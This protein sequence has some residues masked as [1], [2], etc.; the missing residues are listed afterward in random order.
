MAGQGDVSERDLASVIGNE[1][2]IARLRV[3]RVR[4]ISQ[5]C[6]TGEYHA[7]AAI[8]VSPE[9]VL[10]LKPRVPNVADVLGARW[11]RAADRPSGSTRH[12][13]WSR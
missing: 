1:P 4:S 7:Q 13:G 8:G 5:D 3:R 6:D 2:S 11:P 10:R 12:G 9:G